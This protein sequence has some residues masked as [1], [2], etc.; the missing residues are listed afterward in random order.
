M[1]EL[2]LL[3]DH[4]KDTYELSKKEQKLRNKNFIVLCLL[5]AL[6]FLTL[7]NTEKAY[8]VFQ[9][10]INIKSENPIELGDS[11]LRPL[12]WVLVLYVSIRYCQ[13]TIYVERQ[14]VYIHNLEK[15]I[16]GSIKDFN[17]EGFNY[18]SN[19]PFVL[20]F[21]HIFYTWISPLLFII[22]NTVRIV[23]E[24]KHLGWGSYLLFD[25]SICIL[26]LTLSISYMCFING[27]SYNDKEKKNKAKKNAKTKRKKK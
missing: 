19:R 6:S 21:I 27:K 10:I 14:Y 2:E 22:I 9:H 5:E 8:A 17:R 12:L 15:K 3:Y 4:Y 16:S 7:L 13:N 25:G 20:K 23:M 18:L 11:I 24:F 1:N 26:I